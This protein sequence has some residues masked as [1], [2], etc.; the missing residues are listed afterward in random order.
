MISNERPLLA[1]ALALSIALHAALIGLSMQI[2]AP[3]PRPTLPDLKVRLPAPP[4]ATVAPEAP[5]RLLLPPEPQQNANA[6]PLGALRPRREGPAPGV[7]LPADTPPRLTGEAALRAAE[8]LAR[9]LPYPHEAIERGLQGEALVLLFLD[10]A[11]NVTAARLEASSGHA[12]LDD[13]AVRAARQLHSLPDSA[14][15]EALL[16]VRFRLR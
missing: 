7:T 8:Q 4:P 2:D 14:P 1:Q 5:P 6:T 9:E 16:P 3:K 12:I 10:S 11:G 13:A 15:R